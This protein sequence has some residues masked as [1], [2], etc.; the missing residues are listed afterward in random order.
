[1]NGKTATRAV[2]KRTQEQESILNHG[3]TGIASLL[4]VVFL[5][6][7][8]GPASAASTLDLSPSISAAY[9]ISDGAAWAQDTYSIGARAEKLVRLFDPETRRYYNDSV[10]TAVAGVTARTTLP[11]GLV[12]NSVQ[13]LNGFVCTTA[14]RTVTCTGNIPSTGRISAVKIQAGVP[15]A[16]PPV[17]ATVDPFNTFVES[18]EGNNTVVCTPSHTLRCIR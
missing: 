8:G 18:N 4:T 6:S 9:G 1:V 10:P 13:P 17:P 11:T 5:T 16:S 12:I 3:I 15:L 14:A 2:V 7:I